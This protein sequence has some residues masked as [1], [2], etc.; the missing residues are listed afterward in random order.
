MAVVDLSGSTA[1]ISDHALEVV[2]LK[3]KLAFAEE[4]I[5]LLESE[6]RQSQIRDEYAAQAKLDADADAT[7]KVV[8]A[9]AASI[10]HGE[11][12]IRLK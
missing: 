7:S 4:Q 1:D 12:V 8:A 9:A 11:E 3:Q 5:Q 2:G 10:L 6:I